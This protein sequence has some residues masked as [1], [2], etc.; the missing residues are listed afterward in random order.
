MKSGAVQT[1]PML[2][3]NLRIGFDSLEE[4][5][6]DL[7]RIKVVRKLAGKGWALVRDVKY[8]RVNEL[9]RLF[10]FDPYSITAR[11]DDA[12]LHSWLMQIDQQVAETTTITLHDLFNGAEIEEDLTAM[13]TA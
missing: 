3:M 1:T 11:Q 2:S 13:R 8:I 12:G 5:L 10:V 7:Y 9:Y 6:E 4:I